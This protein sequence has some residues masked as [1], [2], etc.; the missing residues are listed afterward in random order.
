MAGGAP[1]DDVRSLATQRARARE[2]REFAA[3]DALRDRIADAGWAI[4]DAPGGGWQLRPI[5]VPGPPERVTPDLVPSLLG[6][7]ATHD[8]SFHW[9]VQGWPDDVDRAWASLRSLSARG[10]TQAVVADI[11]GSG[12]DRWGDDV[13]VLPLAEGTGWA[14]AM[15]A[16]LRRS[17]AAIAIVLDGSV[18][19]SGDVVGPIRAALADPATGVCGPFGIATTD[20]RTFEPTAGPEAD[21]IEGYLMALRRDVLVDVGGF[22]ERFRWY[23][24]ADIELSFR[25]KDRGLRAVVVD[26]PVVRHEHRSWEAASPEERD[27]WSR[28]NYY[29]FLDRWRDRFDLT[30]AGRPPDH[31]PLR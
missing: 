29:R 14:A 10:S 25:I 23:R 13:E 8:V 27:R 24:S 5:P 17:R 15:N 12:T 6:E 16:G 18:E 2:A 22:D 20:L 30:V 26:V 19:A 31:R 7:P 1:P 28:R 4:V 21:A 9:V 3:A 11:A